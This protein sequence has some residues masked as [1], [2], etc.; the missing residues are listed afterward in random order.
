[1]KGMIMM[2][3]END[4]IELRQ[5]VKEILECEDLANKR[6][7]AAKLDQSRVL[8][9]FTIAMMVSRPNRDDEALAG[10]ILE[11]LEY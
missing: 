10:Q 8:N 4:Y 5:K 11:C 3:T 1:M 6:K 9:K 2:F 7:L